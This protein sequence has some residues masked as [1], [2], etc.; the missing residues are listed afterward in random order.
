MCTAILLRPSFSSAGADQDGEEDVAGGGGEPEA[1]HQAGDARTSTSS[2]EG[3]VAGDAQQVVGEAGDDAGHGERAD[4]QT[5]AGQDADQL[6]EG[7]RRSPR[8]S[9][10][11]VF[12]VQRLSLENSWFSTS[13]SAVA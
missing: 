1:Q 6:D 3:V 7:A 5:A 12:S 13:S 9:R 8:G 2:S 4:Q 10:T 11:M